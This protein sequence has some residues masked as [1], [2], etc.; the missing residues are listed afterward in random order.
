MKREYWNRTDDILYIAA[1]S[2]TLFFHVIYSWFEFL[3][4]LCQLGHWAIQHL[5][6]TRAIQQFLRGQFIKFGKEIQ[7][8]DK[9]QGMY[10]SWEV[11]F[12]YSIGGESLCVAQNTYAV[13]WFSGRELNMVFGLQLSFSRVVIF[14]F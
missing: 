11:M 3:Y 13:K 5:P 10:Y 4:S 9:W 12:L 2:L 14:F 6:T 7:C 8:F 1:A